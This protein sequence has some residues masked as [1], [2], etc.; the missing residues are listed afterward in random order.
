MRLDVAGRLDDDRHTAG[1]GVVEQLAE[2]CD[3]AG[4]RADVPGAEVGVP[5]A[6]GADRGR[7]ERTGSLES[8]AWTAFNRPR[9]TTGTSR[10][11]VLRISPGAARSCPAANR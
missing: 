6:A 8:L 3:A 2:R 4:S 10:F 11:S 9:P 5:V 7:R 1:R